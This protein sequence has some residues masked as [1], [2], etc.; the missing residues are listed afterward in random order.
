MKWLRRHTGWI[1]GL[2][3]AGFLFWGIGTAVSLNATRAQSA[4]EIFGRAVSLQEYSQA[5]AA[6]T[7]QALLNH[8]E[9]FRQKVSPADLEEQAWERILL[10]R[11]AKN[12]RLQV[13]DQEVVET[14]RK[15]PIF[16]RNGLFDRALYEAIVRYTLGSTSRAF[17]EEIRQ[18]L[19]I[20]KL[21]DKAFE[22]I[23][24]T[25]EELKA[26]FQKQETSIQISFLTLPDEKTAREI[27]EVTRQN[28]KELERI[29]KGWKLKLNRSDF[30]KRSSQIPE[31]GSGSLFEA[32]FT[33]E[34]GQVTG[35]LSTPRGWQVVRLEKKELPQETDFEN[36]KTDLEKKILNGK[37][38]QAY[39]SWY[40]QL[41]RRSAPKRR[42]LPSAASEGAP[43]S[44]YPG[45]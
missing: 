23:S 21:I 45:F 17:E 29:S 6:V 9:N 20:G 22:K 41:R 11:E 10:L 14:L 27:A 30:F 37:K 15:S 42:P 1:A 5:V 38:L 36:A 8:G 33:L 28:P 39:M 2:V 25:P 44:D 18:S 43:S 4:G 24:V 12:E 35:P 26:A 16:Q 40:Q 19:V 31:L 13:S 34:P 3:V 7:R 32:A